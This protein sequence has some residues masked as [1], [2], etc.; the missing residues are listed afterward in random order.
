[1]DR[2]HGPRTALSGI[3]RRGV[4]TF[5]ARV[6][7]ERVGALGIEMLIEVTLSRGEVEFAFVVRWRKTPA[8]DDRRHELA[9]GAREILTV[10]DRQRTGV[11]PPR[12]PDTGSWCRRGQRLNWPRTPSKKPGELSGLGAASCGTSTCTLR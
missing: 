11:R 8:V 7:L 5:S 12:R 3:G 10:A 1:M 6:D 9:A 2:R 4:L